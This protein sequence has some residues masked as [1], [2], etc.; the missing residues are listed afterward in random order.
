[1]ETCA[2]SGAVCQKGVASMIYDSTLSNRGD[3]LGEVDFSLVAGYN[4]AKKEQIK[5]GQ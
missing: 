1:M 4:D 3:I 2:F 5:I